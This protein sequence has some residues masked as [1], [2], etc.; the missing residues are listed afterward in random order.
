MAIL[1]SMSLETP[2]VGASR[3]TWGTTENANLV[4]I[5]S[6]NHIAGNGERV[7][8]GGLNIDA[9]LSFG[10]IFGLI[11]MH[12]VTFAEVTALSSN[13]YNKSLFVNAA[14][15]QLYFRD[16]LGSNVKL[17]VDGALNVAGFAGGIGGDY[18]SVGAALNFDN[19]SKRY[20]HRDGSGN[21][22]RGEFGAVKLF[23]LGSAESIGVTLQVQ[24]A[25]VASYV[26]EMPLALPASTSLTQITSAGVMTYSN[27]LPA[28][29]E[30]H[31]GDL[32][33]SLPAASALMSNA[34]YTVG[35]G[36]NVTSTGAVVMFVPIPLRIGDRIKLVSFERFGD[37]AV[38]LNPVVLRIDN[39]LV[40]PSSNVLVTT[41]VTNVAA[42]WTSTV[43][44]PAD[45]TIVTGDT[46]MLEITVSATGFIL[47]AIFVT[48]DRP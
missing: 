17:T 6:H 32:T 35:T 19:A 8:T 40:T 48:Y 9:D 4:K 16:R 18:S 26:V 14:D 30:I 28:T 5:D 22:A 1:P 27:V 41:T 31:H 13:A 34:N 3:G 42:A 10:S 33:F 21:W 36:G 25:Q 11:D 43:L 7:P 2:T 47:G 38:D 23:E 46:L 20:T 15:H 24:A 45:T 44:N 37:G 39:R 12:A 29:T